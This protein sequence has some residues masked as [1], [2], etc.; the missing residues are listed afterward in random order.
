M[1]L[2]ELFWAAEGKGRHDWNQTSEVLAMIHNM[3]KDPKEDPLRARDINPYTAGPVGEIAVV[4]DDISFLK[5]NFQ[6]E[7]KPNG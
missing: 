4:V 1:T 3:L 7:G 6:Q 5:P 2:R